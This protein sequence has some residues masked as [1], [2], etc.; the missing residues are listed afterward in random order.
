[1]TEPV[2]F[3]SSYSSNGGA[4]VEVA[5]NLVGAQA[6]VPV[7]DSK[8][9]GGPALVFSRDAWTAFARSV[10]VGEFGDV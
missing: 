2:W 9:P 7:R 5:T 3:K 1:M 6:I 8:D 4:C 10:A